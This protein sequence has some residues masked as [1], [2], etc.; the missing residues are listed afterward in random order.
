MLGWELEDQRSPI[1]GSQALHWVLY[2]LTPQ[3]GV[4]KGSFSMCTKARA[5]LAPHWAGAQW[6]VMP[7]HSKLHSPPHATL[8]WELRLC[9]AV[10]WPR[11]PQRT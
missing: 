3:K 10:A 6:A 4:G 7:C 1:E 8:L 5:N 2:I 9:R 11:R